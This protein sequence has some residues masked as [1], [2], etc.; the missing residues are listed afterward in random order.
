MGIGK[1]QAIALLEA[2]KTGT[3]SK[4][5]QRR[6]LTDAAIAIHTKMAAIDVQLAQAEKDFA[7]QNSADFEAF[8]Q[9]L[10]DV[11]DPTP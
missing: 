3:S 6:E 9:A 8:V 11:G 1:T 5:E 7:A 4:A 2:V 10:P